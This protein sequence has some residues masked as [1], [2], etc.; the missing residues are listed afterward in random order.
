M[1]RKK[2]GKR[3]A[4]T[5]KTDMGRIREFVADAEEA[6][7][8]PL[9]ITWAYEAA[10]IKVAVA[11][12]KLMLDCLVTAVNNDTAT[13]SD[14]TKVAFPPHLNEGVCEYLITQGGYFDFKGRDGLIGKIKRFVPVEHYLC[15]AVADK[16]YTATLNQL[17]ALRNFAA[18]GSKQ[19]KAA[20]RTATGM[21]NISSAGAWLKVQGRLEA[22]IK[23]L[24]SLATQIELKAPY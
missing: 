13:I 3:A 17:V 20:A 21:K 10:V 16:K 9:D 2:S 4:N 24:E 7:L 6:G 19:S 11:F 23:T 15:Q 5:F 18:H 12:E 1:S 22:M 8:K 14:T